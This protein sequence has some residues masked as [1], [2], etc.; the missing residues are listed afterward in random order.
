MTIAFQR[1]QYLLNKYLSII[2]GICIILGMILPRL[3]A[4]PPIMMAL[5]LSMQLFFSSF[6]MTVRDLHG[7]SFFKTIM[8]YVVRF[9]LIPPL[10]FLGVSHYWEDIGLSVLLVTLMPAGSATPALC[11]LLRGNVVLSF[12]LV[13]LSAFIVPF[14][15]PP[16]CE[17]L[18]SSA[19]DIDT[20][21]LFI[22]MFCMVIIPFVVH[23][24]F[25]KLKGVSSWI[26]NN[27]SLLVIP[28]MCLNLVFAVAKQSDYILANI[29]S[30]IWFAAAS[31]ILF[32][33]LY[34]F[35]WLVSWQETIENRISFS[36]SSSAINITLALVLAVLHFAPEVSTFMVLSHLTWIMS[37]LCF[38][39]WLQKFAYLHPASEKLNLAGVVSR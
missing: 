12:F 23:I 37:F 11:G 9:I 10:I 28:L 13:V 35:G 32:L 15:A 18:L 39:F 4:F 36:L 25:R 6:K 5:I 26:E 16:I 31:L 27:N 24:P 17:A 38:R 19:I 7:I 20:N 2:L 3:D 1:L 21:A 33:S 30:G 34:L 22:S 29:E 8:F 14:I